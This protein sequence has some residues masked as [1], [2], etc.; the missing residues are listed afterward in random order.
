MSID[1]AALILGEPVVPL[2]AGDGRT[3]PAT[4]SEV[5]GKYRFGPDF[6]QPNKVL[7]VHLEDGYLF[8]DWG[9]LLSKGGKRFI[10]RMYWSEVQFLDHD[11]RK[12]MDYGVF[13][14]FLV[15]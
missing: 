15:E 6:Y 9:V 12:T 10:N 14:G 13:K 2:I 4:A 8:I 3:D 5:I 7:E 1:I 11:S